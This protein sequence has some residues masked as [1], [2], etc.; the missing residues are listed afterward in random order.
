MAE[1]SAESRSKVKKKDF[2]LPSKAG[3]KE[4]KKESG[5]YPMP[6]AAHARNAKARATQQEKKGNL[7]HA[8]AEQI[9][10]KADK[11]LG[12]K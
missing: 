8:Q 9:R 6:D 7:S 11:K 3:S 4:A 5:N 2:G 12:N 10:N 1:L